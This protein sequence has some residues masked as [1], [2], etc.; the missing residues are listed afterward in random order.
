MKHRPVKSAACGSSCSGAPTWL[1]SLNANHGP[2]G[3]WLAWWLP[4]GIPRELYTALP[5][6]AQEA[7]TASGWDFTIFCL[8]TADALNEHG[9]ALNE[10]GSGSTQ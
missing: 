8:Q 3:V 5:S 6:P 2:P 4:K 9:S 7:A 10:H 1:W